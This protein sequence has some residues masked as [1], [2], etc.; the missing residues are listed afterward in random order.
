MLLLL[1]NSLASLVQGNGDAFVSLAGAGDAQSGARGAGDALVSLSGA[2][3]ARHGVAGTAA[4]AL[5]ATGSGEARVGAAGAGNG[6]IAAT[7]SG[8]SVVGAAAQGASTL[9]VTAEGS[10]SF[11]PLAISGTGESSV[12]IT[13]QG[14]AEHTREPVVGSGASLVPMPT[15]T[16]QST[17]AIGGIGA[18]T[19]GV[20]VLGRAI[21]I[22]RDRERAGRRSSG[23]AGPADRRV[24]AVAARRPNLQPADERRALPVARRR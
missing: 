20:L 2:G 7:G 5:E 22:E 24:P 15:G 9:G 3:E 14:T 10:A 23:L 18:A 16:G 11:T 6:E 17:H 4:S 13:G 12:Q 8:A 1:F 21:T 19:F